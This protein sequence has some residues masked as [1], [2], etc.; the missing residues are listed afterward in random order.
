MEACA[1]LPLWTPA[2]VVQITNRCKNYLDTLVVACIHPKVHQCHKLV[3]ILKEAKNPF[4]WIR[5]SLLPPP[6]NHLMQRCSLLQLH[7]CLNISVN[8]HFW[9]LQC[10]HKS[11]ERIWQNKWKR[12]STFGWRTEIQEGENTRWLNVPKMIR[13][14]ILAAEYS[15]SSLCPFGATSEE[16]T[17][18]SDS[19]KLKAKVGRKETLP[20]FLI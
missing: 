1:G 3:D 4:L 20:K 8:P 5:C 16:P 11:Y 13:A 17:Y 10:K 14:C 19:H 6:N 15:G 9:L 7:Q 2:F 12:V 18:L